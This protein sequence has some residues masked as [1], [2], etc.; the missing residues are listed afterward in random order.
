MN[1]AIIL[2]I[3]FGVTKTKINWRFELG[4]ASGEYEM[5]QGLDKED[6]TPMRVLK[7]VADEVIANHNKL[8]EVKEKLEANGSWDQWVRVAGSVLL[9]SGTVIGFLLKIRN[10]KKNVQN[11]SGVRSG[12]GN[13]PVALRP[14]SGRYASSF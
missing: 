14:G 7:E 11:V 13:Q 9:I 2:F 3:L 4:V 10:I 6:Y 8:L 5:P 1:N 12:A